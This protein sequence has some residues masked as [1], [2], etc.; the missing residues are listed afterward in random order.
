MQLTKDALLEAFNVAVSENGENSPIV[1]KIRFVINQH[2]PDLRDQ[3]NRPTSYQP[4]AID[5]R[6]EVN[7][8]DFFKKKDST[9]QPAIAVV[10]QS[11]IIDDAPDGA[12]K[13]EFSTDSLKEMAAKSAE[14]LLKE[15]GI[16]KLRAAATALGYKI[17]H[18]M[19]HLKFAEKFIEALNIS[20]TS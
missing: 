8:S 15:Q 14:D 10:L 20:I 19:A 2:F 7:F 9:S 12:K 5:T 4:V 16:E 17:S 13:D 1:S 18:Q 11:D 6:E 3:V